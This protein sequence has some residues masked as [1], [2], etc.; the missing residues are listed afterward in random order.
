MTTSPIDIDCDVG[1]DGLTF[2]LR[3]IILIDTP[4]RG[5]A[6]F[7]WLSVAMFGSVDNHSSYYIGDGLFLVLLYWKLNMLILHVELVVNRQSIQEL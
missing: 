4:Y 5:Y 2:Y 6:L 3:Y 7:D 1:I